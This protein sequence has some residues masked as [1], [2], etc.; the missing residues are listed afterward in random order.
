MSRSCLGKLSGI[1]VTQYTKEKDTGYNKSF[2]IAKEII[3]RKIE[4]EK[5]FAMYMQGQ[6][7]NEPY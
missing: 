7:N 6:G 1:F 4:W 5:I 3:N 2:H